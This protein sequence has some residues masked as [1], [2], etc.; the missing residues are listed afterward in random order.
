[1]KATIDTWGKR[2]D[3]FVAYSTASDPDYNA[4]NIEHEGCIIALLLY[5][6]IYT[7]YLY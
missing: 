3:G 2:C 6:I 1:M 7:E 4:F 5:L